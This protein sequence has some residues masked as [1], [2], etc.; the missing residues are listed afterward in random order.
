MS[1][2]GYE[3]RTRGRPRSEEK[4]RR[5]LE[6]ATRLFTEQGYEGTS[7][8]DIAAAAGVSKQTV[9]SHYESKE[10]LFGVAVSE[11]CKASG[12]DRS[13]IDMEQP[14]EV[15]VPDVARKF[16]DLLKSPEALRIYAI[17]TSSTGSH[18]RISELFYRY[19]P[20][21]TVD[22]FADYLRRQ[23]D[24]GQLAVP[25]PDIAAWQFLC[26]L[27]GEAH[28]RAQFGLEP[29]SEDREQAYIDHCVAVFL[30]AYAPR[31]AG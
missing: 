22:V 1:E 12:M 19:G 10:N 25:D 30:R 4:R 24:T 18:P 21:K 13:V 20:K 3:T 11:K 8:D 7:V 31:Q 23:N 27:K 26:M 29:L 15:L 6:A 16:V 2:T 5:I 28:M 9:Y 17:C 14:P